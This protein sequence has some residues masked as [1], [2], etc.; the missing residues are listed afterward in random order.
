MYDLNATVTKDEFVVYSGDIEPSSLTATALNETG[1]VVIWRE[2]SSNNFV[3]GQLF[4][5]KGDKYGNKFVINH[6]ETEDMPA[7]VKVT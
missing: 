6:S 4:D 2:L 7:N 3:C 5:L 1:F